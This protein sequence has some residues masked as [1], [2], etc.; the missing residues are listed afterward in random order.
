[1]YRNDEGRLGGG[2]G[3]RPVGTDAAKRRASG[4]RQKPFD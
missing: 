4:K 2:R 1:V 3:S